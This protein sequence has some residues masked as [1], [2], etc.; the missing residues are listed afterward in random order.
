MQG[1]AM[2]LGEAQAQDDADDH[3]GEERRYFPEHIEV[4]EVWT[5]TLRF[6]V[7]GFLYEL[8]LREPRR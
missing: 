2:A 8:P 1:V 4:T 6:V 3:A 7:G 5:D